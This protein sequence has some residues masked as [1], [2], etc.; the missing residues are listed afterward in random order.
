M[1][2]SN[3]TLNS[4]LD[5]QYAQGA[6]LT[7]DPTQEA[8][9]NSLLQTFGLVKVWRELHPAARNYTFYSNPHDSFCRIDHVFMLACK[10][11]I[12]SSP[13]VDQDTLVLLVA[14][15][16]LTKPPSYWSINESLL[17]TEATCQ[18]I[19][20]HL[21]TLQTYFLEIL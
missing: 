7:H 4:T 1:G 10:V 6:P 8:H 13:W 16:G 3:V 19:H 20:S 11:S 14:L 5:K 2:D 17:T 18:K 15:S 12:P 9:M 21:Q